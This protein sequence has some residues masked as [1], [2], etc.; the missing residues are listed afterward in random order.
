VVREPNNCGRNLGVNLEELLGGF[1]IFIYAVLLRG[2]RWKVGR[3]DAKA[4]L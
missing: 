3:D 1:Y 2:G 4:G